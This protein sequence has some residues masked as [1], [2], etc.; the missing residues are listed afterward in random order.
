MTSRYPFRID[1]LSPLLIGTG[2]PTI[3]ADDSL[4]RR[5]DGSPYLP[6]TTLKGTVRDL[7]RVAGIDRA[8]L[9]ATFGRPDNVTGSVIVTDAVAPSTG[10]P[11]TS[12]LASVA[13]DDRRV[14]VTG[15]LSTV[16]VLE[17]S[18]D[19]SS[20]CSF[21][22]HVLPAPTARPEVAERAAGLTLA[23]LATVRCLG[24]RTRRGWG[25]VRVALAP[26]SAALA[27]RIFEEVA[28]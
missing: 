1:V 15:A 2:E 22:G 18:G 19:P 5:L 28:Q 16:E 27:A 6:A 7:L 13:L 24:T 4:P 11:R 14:A 25:Q 21:F 12:L 9:D 8:V 20:P 17:P 26:E 10:Q 23:G 3:L